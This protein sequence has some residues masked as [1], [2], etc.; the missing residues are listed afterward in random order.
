MFFRQEYLK[1]IFY[2]IIMNL[3]E[4]E[5]LSVEELKNQLIKYI[6]KE[7]KVKENRKKNNAKYYKNKKNKYV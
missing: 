2:Y 4:I 3:E 6:N 5:K 7:N 1:K